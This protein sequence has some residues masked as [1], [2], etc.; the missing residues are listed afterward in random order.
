MTGYCLPQLPENSSPAMV[1]AKVAAME[2]RYESHAGAPLILF[3]I[4][5][6]EA[7]EMR[8]SLEIPNLGSMILTHEWDGRV[9]GLNSFPADERPGAEI[10]FWSFRLMVALGLAMFGVGIWSAWARWRGRLYETTWLHRA[11]VLMT[12]AGF[13]AVLA[14]WITTEVG[15]QP[16]TV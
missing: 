13:G 11:A 10:V 5:D 6:D 12:P 1:P 3:G 8:F 7:G 14:G 16:W 9:E 15:R 4:P 2:G